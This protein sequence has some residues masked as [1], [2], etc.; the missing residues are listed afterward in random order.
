MTSAAAPVR[1]RRRVWLVAG[2]IVVAAAAVAAV[3]VLTRSDS[4]LRGDL[5]ASLAAQHFVTALNAGDRDAAAAVS[6]DNFADAARSAATT[7]SDPGIDFVLDSVRLDSATSATAELTQR[8]R[9]SDTTQRQPYL[10]HLDRTDGRWL[11]CGEQ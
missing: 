5:S 6:C 8:L 11:V 2:A 10:V 4:A 7:G 1:P 3:V 9:I